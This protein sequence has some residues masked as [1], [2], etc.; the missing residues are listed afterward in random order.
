M[1]VFLSVYVWC[2]YMRVSSEE[3]TE[4][5]KKGCFWEGG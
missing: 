2:V 4:I 5:G 1:Y 3:F